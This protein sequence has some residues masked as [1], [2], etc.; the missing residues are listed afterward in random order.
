MKLEKR[1]NKE[2]ILGIV[3][4]H[5][6]LFDNEKEYKEAYTFIESFYKVIENESTYKS[7]I[8][9]KARTK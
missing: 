5:E 6:N 9:N 8:V 4:K 3:S 1:E 2:K 7:E